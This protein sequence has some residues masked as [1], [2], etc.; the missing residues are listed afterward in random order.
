M[1]CS[2]G[3]DKVWARNWG[4]RLGKFFSEVCLLEQAF[5]KEE[6]TKVKDHMAAVARE[7]GDTISV[8]RFHRFQLGE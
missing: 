8:A 2:V 6:K 5:I 7:L 3:K 4:G 1:V